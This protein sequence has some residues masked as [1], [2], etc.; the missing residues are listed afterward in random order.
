MLDSGQILEELRAFGNEQFRKTYK[1]HGV[2]GDSFGV[3]FANLK[4]LKKK[5]KVNHAAAKELWD[6]GNHD[7]RIF[8]TMIADPKQADDALL[9]RW[10]HDLQNYVLTDALSGYVAQTRLA[11]E[12][13][14]QWT[15]SSSEWIGTT[16]WNLLGQLAM[17]E[18]S[19]PDEFFEPFLATIQ[20]DIHDAK[21]R[22]RYA[23]NGAL[24]AI[25]LRSSNL[26]MQAL[27]VAEQI[28]EVI[29]DHGDTNCKTPDAVSYIQKTSARK[30]SLV[31]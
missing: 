3:S 14:E 25:G 20:R 2:T 15:K 6:S 19:L 16:G 10:V 4:S 22:V 28:G 11:R 24:I 23:M 27:A 30:K 17:K 5:I 12:K 7:A 18:K 29:V 13:M 8:A 1:R 26:Q 9:E 31:H 21:N